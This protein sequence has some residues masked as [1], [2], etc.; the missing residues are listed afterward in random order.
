MNGQQLAHSFVITALRSPL[1]S[2]SSNDQEQS[3][4]FARNTHA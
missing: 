2:Y 3:F 4:P 1:K